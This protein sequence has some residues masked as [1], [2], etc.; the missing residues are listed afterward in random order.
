M[1]LF[2]KYCAVVVL[3]AAFLTLFFFA[4][5]P[6]QLLPFFF[7]LLF[8]ALLF[9]HDR[10]LNVWLIVFWYDSISLS[11]HWLLDI[12]CGLLSVWQS[13]WLQ[14]IIRTQ[15][16]GV[17]ID[18]VVG[19]VWTNS[20]NK[21]FIWRQHTPGTI[22]HIVFVT[23]NT[24]SR[25]VLPHMRCVYLSVELTTFSTRWLTCTVSSV[26]SLGFIGLGFG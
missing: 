12:V 4:P 5:R 14:N 25:L 13:L 22:F 21:G 16:L 15:T 26:F 3:F 10:R 1:F 2:S 24:T 20:R 18:D 11:S 9:I 23:H 17:L 6:S 8:L 19:Y 7:L